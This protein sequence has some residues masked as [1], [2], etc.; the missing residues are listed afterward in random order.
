[1]VDLPIIP[2]TQQ[3]DVRGS[4]SKASPGK[5][6]RSYMNNKLNSGRDWGH[7]SSGREFT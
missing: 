4:W 7:S 1:M 5:S 6:M 2:A 3:V